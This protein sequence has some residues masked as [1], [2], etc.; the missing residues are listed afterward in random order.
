MRGPYAQ[1]QLWRERF[2]WRGSSA[3]V[4]FSPGGEKVLVGVWSKAEAE[5]SPA[6]DKQ[7]RMGGRPIS[8]SGHAQV[9]AEAGARI[10]FTLYDRTLTNR[11]WRLDPVAARVGASYLG[12]LDERVL[13]SAHVN[14]RV[15]F[16]VGG[17]DGWS[18]GL[19][20]VWGQTLGRIREGR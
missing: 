15:Q 8:T 2:G 11:I 16:R 18:E 7:A 10:Q 14:G 19:P 20:A 6:A 13:F 1:V 4:R 9:A 5:T 17:S 12:L 3:L